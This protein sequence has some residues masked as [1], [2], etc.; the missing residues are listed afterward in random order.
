MT[1]DLWRQSGSCGGVGRRGAEIGVLLFLLSSVNGCDPGYPPTAWEDAAYDHAALSGGFQLLG[2]HVGRPCTA[3]HASSD[4][5]P[6]FQA[7]DGNDCQACHMEEYE[8]E[9][10]ALGYP[11][12][13]TLCHTPTVWTDGSF[14][15]LVASGGFELLGVHRS[16]PCTACHDPDTFEPIFDPEGAGDCGACHGADFPAA[17]QQRGFPADCAFCHAPTAWPDG[18][19]DHL[20]SSGSFALLGIHVGLPCTFCH[21]DGSFEPVFDPADANDCVVCHESR[22]LNAHEGS[23]Y[24]TTCA[25]CHTPT[26]WRNGE[27][28]HAGISGGFEL[29]GVHADSPCTACHDPVDFTPLFDPSDETDCLACHQGD[30][31]DRHGG[32][33]YP[34]ECTICHSPT[35]WTGGRFNHAAASGGFDLLG[36][37]REKPCV[38]CHDPATFQPL[39]D[40]ADETDCL[41]CHQA[42]YDEQHGEDGY[43]TA[44]L[45]CHTPTAW[46]D[47]DFDH[48]R[49]YFPI[50]TGE[51]APRW[52]TCATCHTDPGDFSDFTCF[53]CH[54]HN[55]V[56]MDQK[57]GD[58]EGYAYV[59]SACI[60]C[61]PDGTADD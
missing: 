25:N 59:P 39:F 51:H 15:H 14:D 55:R 28:N 60:T 30:Y 1:G 10:A 12:G 33:G 36:I 3:C 29:L 26:F 42:K 45:F 41:A 54:A 52:S 35:S 61:H 56:A 40:P 53:S 47:V 58:E 18:S 11:T 7:E 9:H 31:D 57:H 48:D 49:D 5:A 24:P 8:A 6:L 44:C 27:F 16:L 13:C 34:T 21:A 17:H 37:H 22:Y 19:F 23:G 43:P 2:T 4:Y 20:A 38:S 32:T 46:E 50:F